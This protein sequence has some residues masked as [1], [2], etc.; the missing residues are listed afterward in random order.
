MFQKIT[1]FF[2][3]VQ[4]E[5]AKVSWPSRAALK[6]QTL[7]VIATTLMCSIFIFFVD[8]IISFIIDTIY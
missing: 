7:I 3:D 2:K 4:V 5:M 8:R 1:K 6:E